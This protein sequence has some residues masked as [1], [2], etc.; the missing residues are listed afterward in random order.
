MLHRY[1]FVEKLLCNSNVKEWEQ[2][3]ET[4]SEEKNEFQK[5]VE[6]HF[7]TV[8]NLTA[9]TAH[10]VV[11]NSRLV[12]TVCVFV[13]ARFSQSEKHETKHA[14]DA[15]HISLPLHTCVE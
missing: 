13:F 11:H 8:Q 14:H 2:E 4:R 1:L 7:S 12:G 10:D 5:A 9:T 6:D 15:V 3:T